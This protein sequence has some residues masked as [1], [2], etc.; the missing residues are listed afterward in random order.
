MFTRQV[1][2][3]ILSLPFLLGFSSSATSATDTATA[4][5]IDIFLVFTV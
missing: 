4:T 3:A 5:E 1:F 2:C